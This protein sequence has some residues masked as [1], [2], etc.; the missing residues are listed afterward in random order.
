MA[1]V[2]AAAV[3]AAEVVHRCPTAGSARPAS[4]SAGFGIAFAVLNLVAARPWRGAGLRPAALTPNM[5]GWL[6]VAV[7][8]VPVMV[9]F[10]TFAHGLESSTTVAA[11]GSC[12]VMTPFVQDLQDPKSETL[13]ATHFKNR[14]IQETTATRATRTTGWRGRS[15]PSSAGSATCGATRPGSTTLPIKIAQPYPNFRCLELP[16]GVA[17]FLNSEGH[18]R[19]DLPELM[20]GKTSCLDCHAPAH[21]EQKRAASR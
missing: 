10:L 15:R 14:Y 1:L 5:R 17:E 6:F 7:G 21:P 4:G 18:P 8:L 9:A 3:A 12:H 19:S 2:A 20:A 11:C 16:R 13:A